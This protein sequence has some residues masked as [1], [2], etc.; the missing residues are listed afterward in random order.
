M[1]EPYLGETPDRGIFLYSDEELDALVGPYHEAGFQ[2][3]IHAIGD[4]CVRLVV[5]ALEL[6][7]SDTESDCLRR[8]RELQT[9]SIGPNWSW[10]RCRGTC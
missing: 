9:P 8:V 7:G 6:K 10:W 1:R 3:A 5:D 4:A 2:I